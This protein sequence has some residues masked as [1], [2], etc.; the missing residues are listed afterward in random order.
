MQRV[1]LTGASGFIGRRALHHLVDQGMEVHAIARSSDG[2]ARDAVWHAVDLIE[3]GAATAIVRK[4]KPDGLLH[5]AWIATPG[6]YWTSPENL[7]WAAATLELHRAFTAVG[8]RR[9][10]YVGSCA[11]YDWTHENLEED[12]TPLAPTTP[13]G[14]AKA[15]TGRLLLDTNGHGG[16]TVAWGRIFYLYGPEEKRGRL[17][18]DVIASIL[19]G[20]EIACSDGRQLR[21]FMHVD[22]VTRALVSVLTSDYAGPVNI[23]SGVCRPVSA[24]LDEIIRQTGRGDLVKIGARQSPPGDP[25]RLATSARVLRERIG[26]RPTYDLAEGIADTLAWWRRQPLSSRAGPS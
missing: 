12:I 6:K 18:S 3:P 14:L 19:E 16:P 5:L 11:E 26:F 2:S 7:G 9:G 4:V 13:Y 24:I 25:L 22:D 10:V 15:C 23:A 21:D 20:S 17:I 8:G 1:L